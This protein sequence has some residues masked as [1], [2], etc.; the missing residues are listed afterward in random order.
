MSLYP[1]HF[2]TEFGEAAGI[3]HMHSLPTPRLW[4]EMKAAILLHAC[5]GL[6]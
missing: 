1:S 6:T 2:T 4:P 5:K 3:T